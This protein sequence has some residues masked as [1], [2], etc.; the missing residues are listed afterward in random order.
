MFNFK[1]YNVN[2]ASRWKHLQ[3]Q[4]LFKKQDLRYNTDNRGNFKGKQSP[5]AEN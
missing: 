4:Y 2:F 5:W 3:V 1:Y